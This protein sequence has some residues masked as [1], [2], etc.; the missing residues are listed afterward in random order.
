LKLQFDSGLPLTETPRP[1]LRRDQ[2]PE[3]RSPQRTWKAWLVIGVL[4]GLGAFLVWCGLAIVVRCDRPGPDR[5]D[6][7]IERRLFGLLTLSNETLSDVTTADAVVVWARTSGGGK[8]RRGSTIALE[9]TARDGSV[10]RRTRF[11]PSIGTDPSDVAAQIAQFLDDRS[12]TSFSA[13]W[14]PWLVNLAALPFVLF[15]GATF[16][17]ILWRRLARLRRAPKA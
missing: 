10:A 7:T 11:G 12:R 15:V 17:E 14:M 13:W 9:V 2:R 16:G 5:V 4:L 1:A 6:V 8:Q 3:L